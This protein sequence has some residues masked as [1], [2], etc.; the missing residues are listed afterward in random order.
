MNLPVLNHCP[1]ANCHAGQRSDHAASTL[2][3]NGAV[4]LYA[5][6]LGCRSVSAARRLILQK[7]IAYA[8]RPE[9]HHQD[10]D[11]V[12]LEN[13]EDELQLS[14]QRKIILK[15]SAS[16]FRAGKTAGCNGRP[17]L[18]CSRNRDV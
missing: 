1:V 4:F 11:I 14:V 18:V 2:H 10:A 12:E 7:N 8:R 9:E 3:V 16:Y 17:G 15:E 5:I 13:R 6:L